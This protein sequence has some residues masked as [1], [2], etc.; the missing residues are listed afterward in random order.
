[1]TVNSIPYT[2]WGISGANSVDLEPAGDV[3]SKG[4]V[5]MCIGTAD[6]GGGETYKGSW[7]ATS[8]SDTLPFICSV[9]CKH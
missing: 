7:K 8:C 1:M 3:S 9:P 5:K 6:C 4:C 2:N